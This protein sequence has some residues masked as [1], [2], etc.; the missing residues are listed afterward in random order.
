MEYTFEPI[1]E[2]ELPQYKKD[3]QYAFE[4]GLNT[5]EKNRSPVLPE[6]DINN[7]LAKKGSI[8]YGFKENGNIIG[9]A[10]LNINE[11]T[12]HNHLE[13]LYVKYGIENKGIGKKIWKEIEKKYPDT[14]VWGTETPYFDQRNIH[15]YIN[16]CGFHAVEF[17][18]E[19]HKSPNSSDNSGPPIYFRFEKIMK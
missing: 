1:T 17:F 19:H 5:G 8:A 13:F 4:K 10:I 12:Q 3:M 7:S 14:K 16:C 2:N 15:F 6:C 18:N 9:G 11:E